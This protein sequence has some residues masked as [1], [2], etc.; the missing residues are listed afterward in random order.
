MGKA[1]EGVNATGGQ[2]GRKIQKRG[3]R[4]WL[5]ERKLRKIQKEGGL[6]K[7]LRWRGCVGLHSCKTTLCWSL[8]LEKKERSK[9]F[10]LK[11]REMGGMAGERGRKGMKPGTKGVQKEVQYRAG[12]SRLSESA[13]RQGKPVSVKKT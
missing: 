1:G 4:T 6:Q 11:F 5:A 10:F 7:K 9:K 3:L 13:G 12:A 8:F 2:K